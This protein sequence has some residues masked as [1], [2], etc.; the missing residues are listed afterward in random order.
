MTTSVE[1]FLD[2][3]KPEVKDIALKIR[4]LVRTVLPDAIEEV[5]TGYKTIKYGSGPHM[6]E[7][8]C[9]IA[10]LTSS[11]NL[12]FHYG[13]LIPD[14]DGKLRGTGKLLRHIKFE[15]PDE[16]DAGKLQSLL[17]AAK[18]QAKF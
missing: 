7:E 18:N 16:I 17:I 8:I 15:S 3:Y 10:P 4:E 5:H 13:T 11:V 6:S 14:P 9:Y 12:G 2:S 1:N